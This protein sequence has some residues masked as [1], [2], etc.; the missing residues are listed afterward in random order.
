MRPQRALCIEGPASERYSAIEVAI[1]LTKKLNYHKQP[2]PTGRWVFGQQNLIKPFPA[3][4][5]VMRVCLRAA[6]GT[7]FTTNEL[8]VDGT[9]MGTMR[10]IVGSP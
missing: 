10:F 2:S 6:I 7:R 9:P 4:Y 1:A 5:R 3:N 8:I